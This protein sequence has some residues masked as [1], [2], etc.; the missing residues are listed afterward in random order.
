M[1]KD[2]PTSL[3]K[4]D[5]IMEYDMSANSTTLTYN[6]NLNRK[7][8]RIQTIVKGFEPG[9]QIAQSRASD[10]YTPKHLKNSYNYENLTE[11]QHQRA[12]LV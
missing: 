5:H 12:R 6:G 10:A 7:N 8:P 1:Y 9:A 2:S 11:Y 3:A 4:T